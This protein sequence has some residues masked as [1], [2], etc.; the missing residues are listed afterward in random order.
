MLRVKAK[1]KS[2]KATFWKIAGAGAAFQAGSS[3][4][5][6]TTVVASFVHH[7]TGNVFAVGAVSAVLR[8]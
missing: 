1:S 2:S 5:D 8:L 6:S 4:I 7:L 3:A